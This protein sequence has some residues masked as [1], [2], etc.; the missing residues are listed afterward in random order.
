MVLK[1]EPLFDAVESL[2]G[3]R[4][5]HEEHREHRENAGDLEVVGHGMPCPNMKQRDQVEL[6]DPTRTKQGLFFSPPPEIISS[7]YC[8]PV[9]RNSTESYC[10]AGGTRASTSVWPSIWQRRTLDRRFRALGRRTGS[11]THC[12]RRD[13]PPSRRARQ[14]RL[15]SQRI[16]H[17]H[18][19]LRQ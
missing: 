17:C 7:G 10:F 1:P 19:S 8:A 11:R 9:L 18:W 3:E 13:A 4:V 5:Q 12:R 15:L 16:V 14:R 2:L 6:R